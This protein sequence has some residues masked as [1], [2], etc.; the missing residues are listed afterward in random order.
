MPG[1][2]C[3]TP[4]PSQFREDGELILILLET[5]K[6]IQDMGSYTLTLDDLPSDFS[7]SLTTHKKNI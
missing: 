5:L 7:P 1:I 3:P 6:K 4:P 2:T